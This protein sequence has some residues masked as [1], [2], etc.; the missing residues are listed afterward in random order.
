MPDLKVTFK[1]SSADLRRLREIFRKT[2]TTA[3]DRTAIA[4]AEQLMVDVRAA[5]PPDYVVSRV[6]KLELL[7]GMLKDVGWPLPGATRDKAVSALSYFTDPR[8]L[9]PDNIPGLGFLDDAIMIELIVRE[10]RREIDGYDQFRRYRH[11]E[12]DRAWHRQSPEA[13]DRKIEIKR[14]QIRAKIR[15]QQSRDAERA[16]QHGRRFRL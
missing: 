16:R 10:L 1:L 13:R 5:S 12:W 3:D 6:G 14:K 15:R 4:A 7:I 8:D 9:I 11:G 2:K